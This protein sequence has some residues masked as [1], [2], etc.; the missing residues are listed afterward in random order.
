[1]KIL[2]SG[3]H[4]P[5][6]LTIV[7]YI[8]NSVKKTGHDLVSFDDH[9]F[10]LPGRIRKWLPPL[11][12]LD[13]KRVNK[14]LF[15]LAVQEKPDL[16]IVTQGFLVLK[17][18]VQNIRELGIPI[19]IW[20]IDAPID[21]SNILDAAP[22]YDFL[23]CGGTEAVEIFI[24]LKYKNV[25]WLPFA[26]D[27]QFHFPVKANGNEHAPF[28][29]D[30]VFV[31]SNYPSRLHLFE[32][33]AKGDYNL[34]IWGSGWD[35][36]SSNSPIKKHIQ[37][38]HTEPEEWIKIY[39]LSKIILVAHYSEDQ[40]MPVYQ[41]SPKIYEAL[42]CGGFIICDNQKDVNTLFKDGEH[43]VIFQ[44]TKDLNEKIA[45]YLAHETERQEISKRGRNEVLAKHTYAH[46]IKQMLE[47]LNS[48]GILPSNSPH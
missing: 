5:L 44:D 12:K 38:I 35:K 25:E 37:K 29:R 7:E 39:S 14:K 43:L 9:Q 32:S 18:T 16:I 2:V 6:Y 4:N 42:A 48:S 41:A 1:M 30:V 26:Y 17:E 45:Y 3:Y 8:E 21:F 24:N 22:Y 28:S 34:G 40:E 33:L 15:S 13:L 27:P 36:I 20:V 11:D 46:R 23:F 31:G 10:I 47:T 19:V